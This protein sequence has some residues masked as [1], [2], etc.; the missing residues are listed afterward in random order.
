MKRL[1]FAIVICLAGAASAQEST[2]F[3]QQ[4]YRT[5]GDTLQISLSDMMAISQ[6]RHIKLWQAAKAGN[7]ALA[8]YEA[9]KLRDSL[10]RAANYYVNIPVP[11]VKSADAPLSAIAEA[12][13]KRDQRAFEKA[14]ADLTLSCNSCHQAAGLDFIRMRTPSSSP[15]SNQDFAPAQKAR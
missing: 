15:F 7:W 12:A 4:P 2:P 9:D 11:L 13:T 1:S 3:A 8:T 6:M 14:F 10:Y 5:S